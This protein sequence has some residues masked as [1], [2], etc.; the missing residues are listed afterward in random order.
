MKNKNTVLFLSMTAIIISS[1]II[2]SCQKDHTN[3]DKQNNE[4]SISKY[5]QQIENKILAFKHK[6]DLIRENPSLKTGTDPMEID[7]ANWYL[8]ATSNLTYGDASTTS[9]EYVINSSFIDVPL[10]NGEI[11]WLDVQIAYD[12]IIDSLSTHYNEITADEK[13]LIA[14]DI[15][16]EE[17]TQDNV[18]FKVTSCF[19][20]D[21]ID[22]GVH[23]VYSDFGV[24]DYWKAL[25]SSWNGGGFC[26]GP[27]T[28]TQFDSDA[29]EEIEFKI[30]GRKAVP[31]GTYYYTDVSNLDFDA[32][33]GFSQIWLDGVQCSDCSILNLNDNIPDDNMYDYYIFRSYSEFVNHHD[34][35]CPDE[36]NFY[37]N[38][39][40]DIVYNQAYQWFPYGLENKVFISIDIVGDCLLYNYTTT[41]FHHGTIE[42]GICHISNYPPLEL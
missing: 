14:A 34:C 31:V 30:N 22:G 36:M 38:S 25:G 13:Q 3:I 12:Q 23:S 35:L 41:Y 1:L 4:F 10:T 7:S 15:S 24:D 37:L 28:G 5:D 16:L 29:A 40:E 19:G 26:A 39:M 27:Y 42:Y 8:E 18:T 33:C 17:T 11:L 9:D 20:T 21:P 6:I 2:Y 32:C